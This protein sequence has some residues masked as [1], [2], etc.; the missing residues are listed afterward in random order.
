MGAG[1]L[2]ELFQQRNAEPWL[3]YH[4]ENLFES[5]RLGTAF[6][7]CYDWLGLDTMLLID[8]IDI[9]FGKHYI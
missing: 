7:K 2:V 5:L 8:S 3:R 9:L 1:D 4:V 6:T